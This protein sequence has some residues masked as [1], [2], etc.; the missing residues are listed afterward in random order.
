MFND[1]SAIPVGMGQHAIFY[2]FRTTD[3]VLGVVKFVSEMNDIYIAGFQRVHCRPL[4]RPVCSP[5]LTR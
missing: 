2:V 3:V 5:G 1:V 4:K